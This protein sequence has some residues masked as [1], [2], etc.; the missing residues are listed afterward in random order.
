MNASISQSFYPKVHQCTCHWSFE[1]VMSL[2][3]CFERCLSSALDD[4]YFDLLYRKLDQFC[5]SVP[6]VGQTLKS[7]TIISISIFLNIFFN[8]NC[9]F[10]LFAACSFARFTQRSALFCPFASFFAFFVPSLRCCVSFALSCHI[11]HACTLSAPRLL[12]PLFYLK[13]RRTS[14]IEKGEI[15]EEKQ[16]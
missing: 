13:K 12:S 5:P 16:R 4:R 11:L 10:G 7:K 9:D 15:P 14:E 8:M 1:I 2:R 3:R 6:H